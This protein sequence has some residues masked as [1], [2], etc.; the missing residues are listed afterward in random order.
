LQQ[1]TVIMLPDSDPN[2]GCRVTTYEYPNG[3]ENTSVLFYSIDG[4]GHTW[5]GGGEYSTESLVGRVCYDF[6]ACEHIWNFF[7]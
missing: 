5:P 4:G 1:P 7:D 3:N 6:N 2:D